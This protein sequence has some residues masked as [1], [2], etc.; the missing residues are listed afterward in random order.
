[1]NKTKYILTSANIKMPSVI[2]FISL[3]LMIK[4]KKI[5]YGTA[6]KKERTTELVVSAI[7][8]G[9]RGVGKF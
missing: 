5:I 3:T 7:L 2:F 9:F 1:M 6:W 8:A 4:I